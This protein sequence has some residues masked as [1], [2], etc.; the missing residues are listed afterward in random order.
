M[1]LTDVQI[2]AFKPQG[3]RYLKTDGRGLSL[4]VLP[5]GKKSW[6]FR[7]RLNGRQEKVILGSYPD[8]GP[9]GARKERDRLAQ[10]VAQGKSPAH[11]KTLARAGRSTNPTV[12]E[13]CDRFFREQVEQKLKDP[14]EVQRYLDAE[15]CPPLGERLLKDVGV[16]DCQRLIYAKRDKGRITTALHLRAVMKSVFDYALELQMVTMNPATMVATKYIGR[17]GKR[18]R[19]LSPSEIRVFLRAVDQADINRQFKLALRI[20]LLTLVRKSELLQA[21]WEHMNLEAGEWLI[22]AENTKTGQPHLVY[23]STQVA[24]M[25]LEL[26]I[27]AC[28]SELVLPG[29]SSLRRPLNET[30]LNGVLDRLTFDMPAFHIHDLRR[31]ASTILHGNHFQPDVIEVALGHK[32]AGIRG[33]YNV[34]EY[35]AERKRMLQWWSDYVESIVNESKVVAGHFGAG[36]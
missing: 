8:L 6:L 17:A 33:V 25:I 2:R 35:A 24:E 11:E 9:A 15:I 1:P 30:T 5:S 13:F 26:E 22:P 19:A 23:F 31:T 21:R 12:R 14:S 27:L 28:G 34:A 18:T 32:I 16:L 36:A 29:R 3:N 7:Y 4:D 10:I 20:I